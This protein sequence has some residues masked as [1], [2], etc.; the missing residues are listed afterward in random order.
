MLK[1][2]EGRGGE[3]RKKIRRERETEDEQGQRK[4]WVHI[5]KE[6]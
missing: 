2:G 6:I 1:R 5:G 3:T 4:E